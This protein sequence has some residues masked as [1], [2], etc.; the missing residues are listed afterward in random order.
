LRAKVKRRW[1]FHPCWTQLRR[2]LQDLLVNEHIRGLD[3]HLA[4]PMNLYTKR[5]DG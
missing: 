3:R 2:T 1:K 5:K 4:Q